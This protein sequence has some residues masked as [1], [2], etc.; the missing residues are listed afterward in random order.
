MPRLDHVAELAPGPGARQRTQKR[1]HRLGA[2]LPRGR[3][4]PQDWAKLRAK[5]EYAGIE[6]PF[7]RVA[8]I[9]Q[10]SSVGGKARALYGEDE[11]L[12]RLIPPPGEACRFLGAVE[13]RVDLDRRHAPACVVQF[14][15]LRESGRIKRSPPW[16]EVPTSDANMNLCHQSK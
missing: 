1:A 2:E 8:C 7:D 16:R 15:G 9:R 10:F 6:E 3:K 11:A 4:L 5:L 13:G 12:R 14:L